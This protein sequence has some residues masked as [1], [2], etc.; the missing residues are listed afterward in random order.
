MKSFF[1]WWRFIYFIHVTRPNVRLRDNNVWRN[2]IIV[3]LRCY[4]VKCPNEIHVDTLP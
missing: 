2:Y 1:G 4:R 3:T